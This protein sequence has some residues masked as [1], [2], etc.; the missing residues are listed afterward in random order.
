MSTEWIKPLNWEAEGIE[1]SDTLKESGFSTGYKPPAD[2]MN[3]FLH[4]NQEC[5][6]QL[7]EEVD[8]SNLAIEEQNKT[9]T[10]AIEDDKKA[11]QEQIKT[12]NENVVA[13]GEKVVNATSTDGVAYTATVAGVTALYAGLAITIIPQMASTKAAITLNV[14]N[15]GATNVRVRTGKSTGVFETPANASWLSSGQPILM[16]FSG[17]LWIADLQ[18]QSMENVCDVLPITH[19]GTGASDVAGVLKALNLDK[20]NNSPDSE[21]SV[22]FASEAGEARKLQYALTVRFKGGRTEGTDMWT[23]DGSTSRSVNITPDKIG[24]SAEGHTHSVKDV[25]KTVVATSTDGIAYTATMDGITELYN[26]MEI[27]IIPDVVSTSRSI[28]LNLN[29]LGA[30]PIRRPLSFT[31]FVATSI[32]ADKLYFLSANTP[33]RLM[34]HANYTSGGIWLMADKVKTSAQDLY[35]T[36]PI[37]SGGTG[38]ST[39]EGAKENL[40]ITN[41]EDGTTPVGTSNGASGDLKEL[42]NIMIRYATNKT[43][44]KTSNN[45]SLALPNDGGLYPCTINFSFDLATIDESTVTLTNS[46]GF[47]GTPT[48][49]V[50]STGVTVTGNTTSANTY[51]TAT[52]SCMLIPKVLS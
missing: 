11:W 10:K 34:Y 6:E 24:A 5:I 39:L 4:Q 19:G 32:D 37:E 30:V 28:T 18:K 33:C 15:L 45:R 3:Y 8:A 22:N 35:G 13:K 47:K 17:G 40:G 21:K 49:T 27:T 38:A 31:T 25:N 26:G 1:P 43:T 23:Y 16:T 20:V 14:N 52:I 48:T 9:L 50:T 42:I 36:V 51:C 7:Q 2:V 12:T 41:L 46:S 29:G 44:S